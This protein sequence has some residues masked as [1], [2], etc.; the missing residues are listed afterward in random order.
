M[1]THKYFNVIA[2]T[3]I[4]QVIKS[5][6][7]LLLYTYCPLMSINDLH[8]PDLNVILPLVFEHTVCARVKIR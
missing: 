2:D 4:I 5:R 3:V 7:K 6:N 1:Q 8:W